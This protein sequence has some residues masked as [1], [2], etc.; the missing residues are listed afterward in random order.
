MCGIIGV[1]T[2]DNAKQKAIKELEKLEYRG[3][4]SAGICS[5]GKENFDTTKAVGSI[6][7]LHKAIDYK[8]DTSTTAIAHTRWATHGKA[9]LTNCHPHLSQD[10]TWAVVHN[11]IIENYAEIKKMLLAKNINLKSQTDSE[12]IPNL[13]SLENN[14]NYMMRVIKAC[15]KLKGSY[16]IAC[17]NKDKDNCM[18]LARKDSPL[19]IADHSDGFLVSSDVVTFIGKAHNYYVL[20]NNEFACIENNNIEFFDNN[21]QK[22]TKRSVSLDI[23]FVDSIMG[24]YK[25]FMLKEIF[26]IPT[27]LS[28]VAKYYF[29]NKELVYDFN[30][31]LSQTNKIML[32][33]CGTAYH[34][35]L[36]GQRFFN[37]YIGIDTSAHIASEFVYDNYKID[38]STVCIFISQSG[39]TAD[40]I[41][42]LKFAKSKGATCIALT[43]NVNSSLAFIADYAWPI[44]AG[45]EIA[46]ASTKAY[47]CQCFALYLLAKLY[48]GYD[49][50]ILTYQKELSR[51][52]SC[53][54]SD[55]IIN[56]ASDI[57]KY[58]NIFLIG[59]GI[60]YITSLEASLKIKEI[61]YINT[62][63][64]PSGELKHGTLALIDNKSLVITFITDKTLLEKSLNALH[65]IKAR[66]ARVVVLSC[67]DQAKSALTKSD[68]FIKLQELPSDYACHLAIVHMQ[69]LAY[70]ISVAKGI[71]PDKPRNLAKSVTVE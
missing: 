31:I 10:K 13:I 60:D 61:T 30:K 64:C 11:G 38:T 2:K 33:G 3:Y 40:T 14:S 41:S 37:E 67:F 42:A 27:L 9:N 7:N 18:Y 59:R 58:K 70:Y 43:N 28:T 26:Q 12:I 65:E 35:G 6:G 45:V 53:I 15:S 57:K 55:G 50:N 25:H 36:M 66:G 21:G 51:A 47:N 52:I 39:E 23:N 54:A 46:V 49:K 44:L 19:Y 69:L 62:I 1:I 8:D 29:A 71:N 34:A 17:I 32:I 24:E 68:I 5:I 48:N 4:D 16:A 63:A 20:G 56:L 22:Q